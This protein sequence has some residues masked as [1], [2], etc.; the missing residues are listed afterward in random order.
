MTGVTAPGTHGDPGAPPSVGR[1]PAGL[2][3]AG[4]SRGSRWR[5]K[6]IVGLASAIA[7]GVATLVTI[8][9][10]GD[11]VNKPFF[12][13]LQDVASGYHIVYVEGAP[14]VAQSTEE[15][16]VRRPFESVDQTLSG[17]PPGDTLY[18][19]TV[20]RLGHQVLRA[21][22]TA[23]ATLLNVPVTAAPADVRLD[24]VYA[25]ARD[26]HLLQFRR[27][28]VV[29][30]RRCRV[31]RSAQSLRNPPLLPL[32]RASR[33]YVDTC[34]DR[35]GL[36]LREQIVRD[37]ALTLSRTAVTVEVG[38][39]AA[40]RG[41]YS[42]TGAPTPFDQGGGSITPLTPDSL[43]PGRTWVLPA[44]P[45]GF[46]LLGRYVVVP[47][48]PQAFAPGAGGSVAAP[49]R[50]ASLVI[51]LEDVYVRGPD[52]LVVEQGETANNA[53]FAPP[54]GGRPVDLGVLG[55]GQLVLAATA[56][57]VVGEPVGE[58]KFVRVTGTVNPHLLIET[59]RAL[60]SIDNGS[61]NTIVTI[62][63]GVP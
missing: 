1:P 25:A 56:S 19:S 10:Q 18:V 5:V 14:G 45:P 37:G 62:P 27:D 16:W 57:S 29:A 4:R 52:V 28:D 30:G 12:L 59:A 61:R 33:S 54:A 36:I 42:S 23:Q 11:A 7:I 44:P 63:G 21:G 39:A 15:L 46:T 8:S 3:P 9:R 24:A 48:Q 51:T 43:P 26:A 38:A 31:L 50:A 22:P 60:A 32:A 6:G 41:A 55:P 34:V 13:P 58:S 17:P 2:R 53:P 47:P 40:A 49:G 20:S 35:A